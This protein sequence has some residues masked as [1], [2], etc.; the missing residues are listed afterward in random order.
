MVA[1]P[2]SRIAAGSRSNKHEKFAH[3]MDTISYVFW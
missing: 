3:A 2:P 1:K